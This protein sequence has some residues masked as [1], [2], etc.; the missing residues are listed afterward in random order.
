[1]FVTCCYEGFDNEPPAVPRGVYSIT[2][3]EEVMLIWYANTER[4]VITMKLV[5]Q[6]STTF[7]I[8]D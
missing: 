8:L 5:K 1:M 3:D 4:V 2:G 6:I 7:L